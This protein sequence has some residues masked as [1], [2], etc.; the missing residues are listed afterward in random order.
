MSDHT[1]I[2]LPTT[3]EG[4]IPR[5]PEVLSV[6]Q[7]V[8][9]DARWRDRTYPV[10]GALPSPNHLRIVHANSHIIFENSSASITD[11]PFQATAGQIFVD[12]PLPN[13]APK[14]FLTIGPFA[15]L[16]P[17]SHSLQLIPCFGRFTI[18]VLSQKIRA[19]IQNTNIGV[20]RYSHHLVTYTVA[21]EHH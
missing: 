14:V 1:I 17:C 6:P 8:G 19:I 5:A 16:N 10:G 21:R 13:V 3:Q 9:R 18:A 2:G 11:L 12:A 4:C 15:R 20:M 7:S